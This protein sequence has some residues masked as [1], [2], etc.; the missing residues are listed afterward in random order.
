MIHSRVG[1]YLCNA[2]VTAAVW[3]GAGG[4]LKRGR[5]FFLFFF[6][7]CVSGHRLYENKSLT[8]NSQRRP[9]FYIM[10]LTASSPESRLRYC[11]D[12][13]PLRFLLPHPK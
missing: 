8:V 5:A 2:A 9:Q 13:F 11:F 4:K 6:L 3:T 7:V 12:L 1:G 10:K